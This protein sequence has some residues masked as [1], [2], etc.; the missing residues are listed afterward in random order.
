MRVISLLLVKFMVLWK[1]FG[2][3]VMKVRLLW[4]IWLVMMVVLEI[5]SVG[6]WVFVCLSK[7]VVVG[8]C[9]CV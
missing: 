4:V 9:F 2:V 8:F 5:C 3:L 6:S 7:L 1:C